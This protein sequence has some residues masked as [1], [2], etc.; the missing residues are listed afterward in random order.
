MS[1]YTTATN[2]RKKE[3]SA[4]LKAENKADIAAFRDHLMQMLEYDPE[5]GIFRWRVNC[6]WWA[7]IGQVAGTQRP[8]GYLHIVIRQQ[9]MMLHRIAWLF[10]T[11]KW[12]DEFIDHRDQCKSNNRWTNLR[13]AGQLLNQHNRSRHRNRTGFLGVALK[14]GKY[15]VAHI[16]I[17][18]RR[19]HIGHFDTLQQAHD[20]Y[21]EAKSWVIELG[22][23]QA[24][25]RIAAK[26]K[27]R[28][29]DKRRKVICVTPQQK[30]A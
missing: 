25:P 3:R 5:T 8:D 20:A 30:G 17:R 16:E 10:T 7:K 4:L 19:Y 15:P 18:D 28:N 1:K 26:R 13:S 14:S 9:Q 29:R 21:L 27:E 12:P 11:G 22:P 6:G 23:D 24:I 2:E